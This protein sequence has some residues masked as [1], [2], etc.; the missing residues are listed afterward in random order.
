MSASTSTAPFFINLNF[1][2]IETFDMGQ[3]FDYENSNFDPLTGEFQYMVQNLDVA[4]D[5]L[6]QQGYERPDIISYQIYGD[7]QYWWILMQYNGISDVNQITVGTVL[8]YPSIADLE[9]LLFS[10]KSDETAQQAA[11][12]SG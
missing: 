7:P 6:I 11:T 3:F 12:A 1:T 4:G 8:S 5:W 2:P 9:S 10:L